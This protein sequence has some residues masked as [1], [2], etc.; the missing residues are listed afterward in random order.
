MSADDTHE[1]TAWLIEQGLNGTSIKQFLPALAERLNQRGAGLRRLNLGADV[2]HPTIDSRSFHW[3]RER[4]VEMTML[5]RGAFDEADAEWVQSPFRHM[6]VNREHFLRRKLG[7]G[8]PTGE[9]PLLDRFAGEG[10]TEYAAFATRYGAGATLGETDGMLSSWLSDAP[11]G[12]GNAQI[13]LLEAIQKPLALVFNRNILHATTRT[14]L[15]TYLGEDAAKRVLAGN[16]ERGRAESIRAVIW[17]SDLS[18]FTRVADSIDRHLLLGL[19]ND[20]AGIVVDTLEAHGGNVLK[21]MGD[22]ML[23]IFPGERMEDACGHALKAAREAIDAAAALSATRSV[24]GL[25]VT[26]LYLALHEGELLYGNFGGRSRLD[27]TV[28]GP[29]VNEAGRMAALSRSIDQRIVVSS[30]FA[31]ACGNKRD[32]LVSLGRYALRGVARPQELF[33]LD[34]QPAGT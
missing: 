10:A 22:G 18:G 16:I 30:A 11:G 26:D 12:F 15:G 13:T 24:D 1:M 21:F 28:L 17:F 25:P 8:A 14:L 32:R 6:L 29:A 31:A 19:L 33:T 20:Y 34:P 7:D 4:G 27:F 9:F 2:L 23:A 5:D 3:T